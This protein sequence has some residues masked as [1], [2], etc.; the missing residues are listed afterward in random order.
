[1]SVHL[2]KDLRKKH[3]IRSLP[4]RKDDEVLVNRGLFLFFINVLNEIWL[5]PLKGNKGKVIQV[6]RLRWAIYIEKLT[7]QKAT[8]K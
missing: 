1:M 7:R 5:G 4:V 6:Y 3:N 8:G 2:S